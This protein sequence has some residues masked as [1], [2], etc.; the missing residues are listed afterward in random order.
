MP[1]RVADAPSLRRPSRQQALLANVADAQASRP[2]E[3]TGLSADD[4]LPNGAVRLVD[5]RQLMADVDQ[6]RKTFG[7]KEM[8][9]LQR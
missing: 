6:P 4:A 2:S 7:K 1:S 3:S 9:E 5:I 8:D